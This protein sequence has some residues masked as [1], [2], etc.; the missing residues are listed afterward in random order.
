MFMNFMDFTDDACM[1]MFTNGQI[2]RMRETFAAGGLH[3]S[4]RF[5]RALGEPWNKG[6]TATPAPGG[7]VSAEVS[8]SVYPNPASSNI[9]LSSKGSSLAG[10]RYTLFTLDGRRIQEGMLSNENASISVAS[11]KPGLYFVKL[12]GQDHAIRFVRQ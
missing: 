3:E 7:T 2:S 9:T 6:V 11:L 4:I 12:S 10:T 8:I 5:S 1:L